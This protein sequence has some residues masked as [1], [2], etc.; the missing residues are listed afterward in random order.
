[1]GV[2][3]LIENSPANI[4]DE[5]FELDGLTLITEVSAAFVVGV[6]RPPAHRA[7]GSER[8]SVPSVE[9]MAKERKPRRRTIS[10]RT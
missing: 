6:R 4:I 5:A 3:Q 1:L 9:R 2:L 10:T 8:K 7:Y